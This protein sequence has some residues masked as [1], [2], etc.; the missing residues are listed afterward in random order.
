M[1]SNSARRTGESPMEFEWQTKNGPVDLNSPFLQF[2]PPEGQKTPSKPTS[3]FITN[4]STAAPSFRNPAFT[5]P[6]K[7]FDPDLYS[8]ASGVE[9]SPGDAADA[10]DT[11]DLPK[12]TKAMTPFRSGPSDREPLFGRYGAAFKGNSPNSRLDH[13]KR[14]LGV[15]I[16]KKRKR[17]QRGDEYSVIR[18]HRRDNSYS[19]SDSESGESRTDSRAKSKGNNSKTVTQGPGWFASFLSGIESRPNLPNILSYYAQLT[20]NTF[21]VFLIIFGVW[22]FWTTIRSDVDKASEDAAASVVAEIEKCARDYITN[23]CG[24]DTRLPALHAVCEN[25]ERCMNRDPSSVGRAR[26]SA[27]TFAEIFNSFIEP[28]SYKA[29][30]SLVLFITVTIITNNLAFG[31]FRSKAHP[32]PHLQPAPYFPPPTPSIWAHTPGHQPWPSAAVGGRGMFGVGGADTQGMMLEGR[33]PS[34]KR[35]ESNTGGVG[36]SP[37]RGRIG[38]RERERD[39]ERWRL[40]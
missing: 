32:T 24:M 36:R 34:K 19:D 10:E 38:R 17:Q 37:S 40:E 2:K 23:R 1:F 21:L 35:G 30:I 26:I 33:S 5:T 3:S 8:E 29:M 6:R 13:R 25:W 28:I 9:S 14:A 11:P 15:P 22:T 16:A 31:M 20:L 27:K 12:Q 18:R 39:A 7:P 4:S